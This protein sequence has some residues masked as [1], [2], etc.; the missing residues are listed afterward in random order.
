[1]NVL[2]RPFSRIGPAAAGEATDRFHHHVVVAEDLATETQVVSGDETTLGE[3]IFLRLGHLSRFAGDEFDSAGGATSVA[4][5]RVQL[6][7][8]RFVFQCENEALA[9]GNIKLAYC[10]HFQSGHSRSSGV[11]KHTL[12][13]LSSGFSNLREQL[14]LEALHALRLGVEDGV[15][16]GVVLESGAF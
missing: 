7:D 6:I 10:F 9:L 8:L 14:E 5:A 16:N 12:R 2:R 15:T 4:S 1:M 3:N 11:L 13:R